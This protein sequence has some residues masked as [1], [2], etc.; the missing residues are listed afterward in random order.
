MPRAAATQAEKGRKNVYTYPYNSLDRIERR[1]R[2]LR[3][4]HVFTLQRWQ[5]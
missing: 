3:E 4:D 1:D 2:F 5:E